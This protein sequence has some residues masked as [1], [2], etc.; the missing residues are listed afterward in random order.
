[1]AQFYDQDNPH[2]SYNRSYSSDMERYER[3]AN[4]VT[5]KS[6][7]TPVQ[8]DRAKV[9]KAQ[10]RRQERIKRLGALALA[11]MI[12]GGISVGVVSNVV[13]TIHNNA[14]VNEQTYSFAKEVIY[15][16]T[17]RTYDNQGY[18]YDYDDIA[19]AIMA[20]GKD[21][22]NELYKAYSYLGEGQ[23]NRVMKYTDYNSVEEY[24][25]KS[26][27]DDVDA[28]S[29]SERSKIIL[30]DEVNSKKAELDA[31]HRELN[32]SAVSAAAE[33]YGL[34]YNLVAGANIAGFKKVAEAMMSQGVV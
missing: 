20:D 9:I 28:W 2:A 13:E 8:R 6:A 24:A 21:F 1:M 17:H 33:E 19:D 34:G 10:Q 27:F 31:M 29:K 26:G 5:K 12:T 11:C 4:N 23:T 18:F 25:K 14:I 15:P 16:N 3:Q 7:M 32:G 22:S 30:N